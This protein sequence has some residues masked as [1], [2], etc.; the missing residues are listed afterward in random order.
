MSYARWVIFSTKSQSKKKY[1]TVHTNH[2]I[3]IIII[4]IKVLIMQLH[5]NFSNAVSV[6]SDVIIIYL[7]IVIVTS[8]VPFRHITSHICQFDKLFSINH[9]EKFLKSNMVSF[10]LNSLIWM[11][12]VLRWQIR[13]AET[14]LHQR[15]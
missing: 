7:A 1:S 13:N 8:G 10:T 14:V 12:P 5:N 15:R 4:I 9:T 3:I 6:K 2:I 11:C